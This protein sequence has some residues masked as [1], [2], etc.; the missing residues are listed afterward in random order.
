MRKRRRVLLPLG[1]LV[2]A[3]LTLSGCGV[4]LVHD[5]WQRRISQSD[6]VLSAEWDYVNS[7]PTGGSR[8][9]GKVRLDPST[10]E[11]QAREIVSSSCRENPIFDEVF[12]EARPEDVNVSVEKRGLRGTCGEGDELASFARILNVV[13]RQPPSFEADVLVWSYETRTDYA[14]DEEMV[15]P[16]AI[17]AETTTEA[18]LFAFATQLHQA[19]GVNDPFDFTGS[20][21]DDASLITNFGREINIAVPAGYD[22]A[23]IF[24]VLAE[25]YLLDHE[26]ISYSQEAGL[27]VAIDDAATLT[28]DEVAQVAGLAEAAGVPFSPRLAD[29]P[30]GSPGASETRQLFL[31][32]LEDLPAVEATSLEEHATV[33]ATTASL[34]GVNEVL[35]YLDQNS[36]ERLNTLNESLT[37][38]TDKVSILLKSSENEALTIRLDGGV[39]SLSDL[40]TVVAGAIK[41]LNETPEIEQFHVQSW[42]DKLRVHVT[43]AEDTAAT[44]V[45][46]T[47]QELRKL[48][49][50]ATLDRIAVGRFNGS[51]EYLSPEL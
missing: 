22:L 48:L 16:P 24:P 8:H 3:T 44:S 20:V 40:R 33:V 4:S 6:A 43:L 23:P 37:T 7:W 17:W 34:E 14:T 32:E 42:P 26:G 25:A 51:T 39:S 15:D 38:G 9:T 45:E 47:I 28:G 36:G 50:L 29:T 31:K 46:A 21:D 10:S 27:I 41:T 13:D 1:L 2:T 12:Y 5:E 35:D 18:D 11:E 30:F 49:Q 19:V